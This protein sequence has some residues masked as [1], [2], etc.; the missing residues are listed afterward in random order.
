MILLTVSG[1]V[2]LFFLL[3]NKWT[4]TETSV[5]LQID[6]MLRADHSFESR[7]IPRR[8]G[9]IHQNR[10]S[11]LPAVTRTSK[12]DQ[13]E[14]ILDNVDCG[15]YLKGGC[16]Y[17]NRTDIG[18]HQLPHRD[19]MPS[20]QPRHTGGYMLS[21]RY[22]EQQTQGIR[23]LLQMQCL[24]DSF[25]MKIVE[26][27]IIRSQFAI[28]IFNASSTENL[29]KKYLGLGD[30]VDMKRWNMETDL[31][32]GYTSISTWED[33]LLNAPRKVVAHCIRYRNPPKIQVPI[34]GFNYQHGC[35]KGCFTKFTNSMEYLGAFGFEL[36][37]KTCSNFID[38]AG[39]VMAGSFMENVMGKYF[40]GEV[41]L[42]VNE[43]RGFFG[44]YR[45]PVLSE[46][47]ITHNKVN[48]STL[49]SLRIRTDTHKYSKLVFQGRPYAA[50]I[51]RIER[52]I[53]HL[54]QNVSGCSQEIVRLLKDLKS[55]HGISDTFLAMDV[56]KFGSSGSVRNNFQPYGEILFKSI[57]ANQWSF[58]EWESSFESIASSDNPAY[59]ANL[60]RTIAASSRCLILFGGGGFQGMARNLYERFHPDPN[61]WCIYK[62][63]SREV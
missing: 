14:S 42:L 44:L 8:D 47:G 55:S 18:M 10:F 61:S 32:F 12:D 1:T 59:V 9:G 3:H 23:N 19:E 36:V 56:G 58:D 2:I 29:T 30:L 20:K 22:Y 35:P 4:A 34:P 6:S 48:I 33:F 51:A 28:P 31:K 15:K 39:S 26:P 13:R 54:H 45:L 5:S 37:Q 50:V 40:P 17:E 49:P 16:N 63:C 7:N 21:F 38:Y 62:I 11:N 43:F 57:Y 53:L 24:A 46:C 25:G 52:I 41:T 27:F 60:Q